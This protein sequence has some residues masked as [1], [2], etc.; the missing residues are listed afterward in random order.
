MRSRRG[1]SR[2]PGRPRRV[3]LRHRVETGEADE[4]AG[5]APFQ[6]PQ[7][8]ALPL[9]PR[10]DPVRERVARL[11]V[12]GRHQIAHDLGVRVHRRERGTVRRQPAAEDQPFGLNP[13]ESS[14]HG[15]ESYSMKRGAPALAAPPAPATM[16]A[17]TMA[18]MPLEIERLHLATLSAPGSS[19]VTP[20]HGFVVRYDGGA[21]LVDTGVGGPGRLLND[22]RVVN[23]TAADALARL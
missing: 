2:P 17:G 3:C 15:T 21:A 19:D 16:R 10:V 6:R 14:V 20:V 11:A 7:A 23:V 18:L 12:E 5:V 22:W 1:A 13:V 8:E 9:E 4:L